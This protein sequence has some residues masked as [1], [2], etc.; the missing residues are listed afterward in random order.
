[1]PS[2]PETRKANAASR[3]RELLDGLS[4]NEREQYASYSYR[5]LQTTMGIGQRSAIALRALFRADAPQTPKRAPTNEPEIPDGSY[6]ELPDGRYLFEWKEE[7]RPRTRVLT[8]EA[9]QSM[10]RAY[11]KDGGNKSMQ[12]VALEHDLTRREFS[13]IKSLYGA[14]KDHEPF[15]LREMAEREIDDLAENQLTMKRRKLLRRVE[16]EDYARTKAAARKW[17]ALEAETLDP[18]AEVIRDVIGKTPE[19]T[20]I[21]WNLSEDVGAYVAVYQGSDLHLGLGVDDDSYNREIARERFL[22]GLA[23]TLEHGRKA[24]GE[25]EYFLLYVGG[26]VAHVDNTHG[27]TSSMRHHQD[28]DGTPDTLIQAIVELYME[29]MVYLLSQGVNVR[30]ACVPGNHD[31]M[32]SRAFISAL[33][34]VYH[35]HPSVSFGN[36]TE[37][38]AYEIYGNNAIVAHHGHGECTAKALGGNLES[39]LRRNKRTALYLY[40]IT[41]NLHH[42]SLK[43]DG[44]C[45]LIQQPSPAP[46]DRYHR[47]KGYATSRRAT[48]GMYFGRSEGMLSIRYIGF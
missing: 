5:R 2:T 20:P 45:T 34:A 42:L 9:L 1:M 16:T 36:L 28:M 27:A 4:S 33:W 24:Y 23:E 22:T 41:G 31:E 17:Y 21:A 25:P 35:A 38:H 43:E 19:S 18:I 32:L 47:L 40:A 12:I 44:G 7:G 39:W 8:E 46:A 11:S 48:I 13:K 10:I 37:S 14:T 29:A 3:A 26:D 6:T 15:T 30:L